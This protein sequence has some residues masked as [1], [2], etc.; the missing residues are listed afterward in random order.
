MTSVKAR[1]MNALPWLASLLKDEPPVLL[2]HNVFTTMADI[3]AAG[4][5]SGRIWWGLCPSSNR[6][7]SGTRPPEFLIEAFPDRVCVGTDSLAS[8]STLSILHELKLMQEI[9]PRT[10]LVQLL[11]FACLNGA[12]ALGMED[13]LGSFSPG[14]IPGVN[15]IRKADLQNLQ[16][17]EDSNIKVLV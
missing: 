16:L 9:T 3:R 17:T 4:L 6:Y 8:N 7:I 14:K 11:R 5:T 13:V 15:L 10:P 1:Q 12:A 2:I